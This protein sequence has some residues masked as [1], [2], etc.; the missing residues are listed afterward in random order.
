MKVTSSTNVCGKDSSSRAWD[1]LTTTV[2]NHTTRPSEVMLLE[3]LLVH[4][5]LGDDIAGAKEHGGSDG[6]GEEGPANQL[7]LVPVY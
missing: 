1:S 2:E 5:L 3:S 7:S 4:S 6:L